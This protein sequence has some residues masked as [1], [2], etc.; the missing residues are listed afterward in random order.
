MSY[1]EKHR[2][3]QCDTRYCEA[4]PWRCRIKSGWWR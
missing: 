1:K 2:C 3:K 4:C